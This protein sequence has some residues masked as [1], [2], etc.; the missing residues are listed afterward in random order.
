MAF[1]NLADL[2]PRIIDDF[3][4]VNRRVYLVGLFSNHNRNK[5]VYF[6]PDDQRSSRINSDLAGYVEVANRV[7]YSAF[8]DYLRPT[9]SETEEEREGYSGVRVDVP[10]ASSGSE[11]TER[12]INSFDLLYN[13]SPYPEDGP[14]GQK[15]IE[16]L[17]KYLDHYLDF[18]DEIG[19]LPRAFNRFLLSFARTNSGRTYRQLLPGSGVSF[20]QNFEQC[21]VGFLLHEDPNL[22]FDPQQLDWD[23]FAPGRNW[24]DADR[25][26]FALAIDEFKQVL[27]DEHPNA[28]DG[29][30]P[31]LRDNFRVRRDAI[32]KIAKCV[33]TKVM[34]SGLP[35]WILYSM[36]GD[37]DEVDLIDDADALYQA[38]NSIDESARKWTLKLPTRTVSV[39]LP[40][41][42]IRVPVA[43][44]GSFQANLKERLGNLIESWA[45][46]DQQQE[47][48]LGDFL[49]ENLT[50]EE[51]EGLRNRLS[52]IYEICQNSSQQA[53]ERGRDPQAARDR[54][55]KAIKDAW[56]SI[57]ETQF[58]QIL[59]GEP[60]LF[61]SDIIDFY[62]ADHLDLYMQSLLLKDDISASIRDVAGRG[63]DY[64]S[65]QLSKGT[66]FDD[67]QHEIESEMLRLFTV[68]ASRAF[69]GDVATRMSALE[70]YVRMRAEKLARVGARPRSE[71]DHSKISESENLPFSADKTTEG[72]FLAQLLDETRQDPEEVSVLAAEPAQ[73]ESEST[74]DQIEAGILPAVSPSNSTA[75]SSDE[76]TASGSALR[77][78]SANR[79]A[80]DS[81]GKLAELIQELAGQVAPPPAPQPGSQGDPPVD[82]AK[83]DLEPNVD[84]GIKRILEQAEV[85]L[86]EIRAIRKSPE[87]PDQFKRK[88]RRVAMA[89][90]MIAKNQTLGLGKQLSKLY[91]LTLDLLLYG[92]DQPD[93]FIQEN[94]L[95]KY[96]DIQDGIGLFNLF[97]RLRIQAQESREKMARLFSEVRGV[98][99]LFDQVGHRLKDDCELFIFN[100]TGNEFLNWV[101]ETNAD[102]G[103]QFWLQTN[104]AAGHFIL[105]GLIYVLES[106]YAYGSGGSGDDGAG[107]GTDA[108]EGLAN[109]LG[110]VL[111]FQS[112]VDGAYPL[113]PIIVSTSLPF[114]TAASGGN[115]LWQELIC[116]SVKETSL[117]STY[118]GAIYIVGPA[119]VLPDAPTLTRP[120]GVYVVESVLNRGGMR[121]AGSELGMRMVEHVDPQGV[122]LPGGCFS[123]TRYNI[124]MQESLDILNTR[125]LEG[126]APLEGS[127]WLHMVNLLYLAVK[128][129]PGYVDRDKVRFC[130]IFKKIAD[131]NDNVLDIRWRARSPAETCLNVFGKKTNEYGGKYSAKYSVDFETGKLAMAV[132]SGERNQQVYPEMEFEAAWL[133]KVLDR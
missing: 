27:L 6:G 126:C 107:P 7:D 52:N 104:H 128:H 58:I 47:A 48:L 42:L 96:Y 132:I 95:T 121:G 51:R 29:G 77:R 106:A 110:A 45:S 49:G 102:G 41:P 69:E 3:A 63:R 74:A 23:S 97:E 5:L 127:M 20:H 91:E 64:I 65:D 57:L 40:K 133:K 13:G 37:S 1:N 32:L 12:A 120:A 79:G 33:P 100:G 38:I 68:S 15:L 55:L 123:L 86:A 112:A 101:S 111:N 18:N 70:F 115:K 67:V 10:P 105:P 117:H 34:L 16:D 54:T 82:Q 130:D 72:D 93:R 19:E 80:D 14:F 22:A 31:G 39:D 62:V 124:S 17:E 116:D 89:E 28:L 99:Y 35:Y 103:R 78:Q 85:A 50:D 30:F 66:K 60:K 56:T 119:R 108:S 36:L 53:M 125:G 59:I 94:S 122:R 118:P 44:R 109:F 71:V 113:P 43:N 88:C 8:E 83:G 75:S 90:M 73:Q 46:S 114:N 61:L 24:S 9:V 26:L 4:R 131:P 21:L 11:S 92:P 84:I 87:T 76:N 129:S 98:R 81:R 2:G 25:N